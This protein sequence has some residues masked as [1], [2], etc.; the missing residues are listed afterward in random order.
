MHYSGVKEAVGSSLCYCVTGWGKT[1]VEGRRG[2]HKKDVERERHAFGTR[3]AMF[4]MAL[5]VTPHTNGSLRQSPSL[6]LF[7]FYQQKLIKF[8]PPTLLRTLSILSSFFAKLDGEKGSI[9]K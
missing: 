8:L 1:R 2:K 7:L 5:N 4:L 3:S 9:W 6:F